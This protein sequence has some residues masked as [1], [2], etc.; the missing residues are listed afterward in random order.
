[1]KDR[2]AMTTVKTDTKK[3]HRTANKL[4]LAALPRRG[5]VTK[6]FLERVLAEVKSADE[7]IERKMEDKS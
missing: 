4:D 1:M 7:A 6:P 2:A 5:Y 3:R